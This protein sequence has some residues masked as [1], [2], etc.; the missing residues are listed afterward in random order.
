MGALVL[1]TEV[2]DT[3]CA[4]IGTHQ[5]FL[6]TFAA[7]DHNSGS[8]EAVST[9]AKHDDVFVAPLINGTGQLSRSEPEL[10]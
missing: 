3:R 6:E 2:L 9:N 1:T 5:A 10:K 7:T 4:P 8:V